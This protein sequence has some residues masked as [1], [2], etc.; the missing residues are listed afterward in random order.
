MVDIK[1]PGQPNEKTPSQ[2]TPSSSGQPPANFS[3]PANIDP[4]G[5]W[6]RFLSTPGHPANA[7]EVQMFIGT[8]LRFFSVMIQQQ[9][10]AAKKASDH[11]KRVEEGKE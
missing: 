6:T 10:D 8:L 5:V 7:K 2:S 4:T 11:L 1:P 9:Q 3:Q